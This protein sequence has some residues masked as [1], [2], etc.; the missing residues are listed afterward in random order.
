VLYLPTQNTGLAA[1]NS[2]VQGRAKESDDDAGHRDAP[3]EET[4]TPAVS[5]TS[6][7]DTASELDECELGE[8]LLDAL[9]DFEGCDMGA[10]E[11]LDATSM[12]AL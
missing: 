9:N 1:S 8:F 10:M 3:A 2:N 12:L 6:G 5:E 4:A 11:G 7:S